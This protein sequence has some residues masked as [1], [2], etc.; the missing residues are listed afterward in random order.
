[1]GMLA[2][3][4]G[5]ERDLGEFDGLFAASGWSRGTTYPVGG[6]YFGMELSPI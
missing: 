1:M 2:V 6:G 3:T 5:M 4:G